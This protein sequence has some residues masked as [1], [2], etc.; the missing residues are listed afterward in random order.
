MTHVGYLLRAT[1]R[2]RVEVEVL[3]ELRR[4]PHLTHHP[5]LHPKMTP[6]P[7]GLAKGQGKRPIQPGRRRKEGPEV[8]IAGVSKKL[9]LSPF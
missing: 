9:M 2:D 1:R 6:Q 3:A 7:G 4:H 8:E 5:L